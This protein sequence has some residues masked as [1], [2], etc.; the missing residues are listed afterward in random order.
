MGIAWSEWLTRLPEF[1]LMAD[2]SAS[3][4]ISSGTLLGVNRLLVAWN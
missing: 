1:R 2:L 3:A 4:D